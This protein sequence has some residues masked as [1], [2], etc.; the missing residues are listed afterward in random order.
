MLTEEYLGKAHEFFVQP[1][2]PRLAVVLMMVVVFKVLV[3]YAAER[4]SLIVVAIVVSVSKIPEP[5]K[6]PEP[7]MS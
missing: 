6:S 5:S 3:S 2:I 7:A 1:H 4:V